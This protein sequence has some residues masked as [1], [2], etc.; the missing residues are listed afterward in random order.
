VIA[1]YGPKSLL[2]GRALREKSLR[3]VLDECSLRTDP[4]WILKN[5][6]GNEY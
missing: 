5:G 6:S 1:G 2:L 3:R 4:P